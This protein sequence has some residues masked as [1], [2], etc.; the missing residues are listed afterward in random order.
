MIETWAGVS[1]ASVVA[2][3]GWCNGE[4]LALACAADFRIAGATARFCGGMTLEPVRS[5]WTAQPRLAGLLA[6]PA[7]RDLLADGSGFSAAQARAAD[8]VDEVVPAGLAVNGALRW[9]QALASS[10]PVATRMA[11]LAI[12]AAAR[13][14]SSTRVVASVR[15]RLPAV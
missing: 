10:A 7:C 3:E 2:I 1:A 12:N 13:L 5:V 14:A 6:K 11:K 9:A 15:S 8:I 4:A